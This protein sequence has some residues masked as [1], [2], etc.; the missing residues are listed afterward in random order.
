[1]KTAEDGVTPHV[2]GFG[3]SLLDERMTKWGELLN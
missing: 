1:M 2:Y 3:Q